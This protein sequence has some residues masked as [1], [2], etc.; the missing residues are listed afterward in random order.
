MEITKNQIK[1]IHILLKQYEIDDCLYRSMLWDKFRVTSCKNLSE[2]QAQEIIHHIKYTYS[3][4]YKL[5]YDLG[6]KRGLMS[7]GNTEHVFRSLVANKYSRHLTEYEEKMFN[8]L[9]EEQKQEL[10]KTLI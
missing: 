9:S 4:D 2:E 5:G 10:I 1:V 8:V 7:L 3:E 6:L